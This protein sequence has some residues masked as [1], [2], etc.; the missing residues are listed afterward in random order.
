[1]PDWREILDREGPSVW[2]I[3]FRVLGNAA[4]AEECYQEA[5]LAAL[6]LSRRQPVQNWHGLLQRLAA[7]RAVD[8]LRHRYRRDKRE[9]A[10]DWE[11]V[12]TAGPNPGQAAEEAELSLQLRAAL[13]RIPPQQAEVFCL[14]CL[15]DWSYGEIAGELAI[16]V[17]G[18]GVLL[19]RARKQLR[20]LLASLAP[21]QGSS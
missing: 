8:R 1:M 10:A 11:V 13:A 2:R 5:F 4:D 7:A 3:I 14:H 12:P 9:L 15:E 17:D 18:V 19:H 6:E 16:S 20:L 21:D